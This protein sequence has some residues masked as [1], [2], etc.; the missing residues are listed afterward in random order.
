MSYCNLFGHM[1]KY[2]VY[3]V[4][5][6]E[7]DIPEDQCNNNLFMMFSDADILL[8]G[9]NFSKQSLFTISNGELPAVLPINSAL[10]RYRKSAYALTMPCGNINKPTEDEDLLSIF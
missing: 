3:V 9:G 8:F 4:G 5:C 1:Q 6:F 10:M 7:P 2:N